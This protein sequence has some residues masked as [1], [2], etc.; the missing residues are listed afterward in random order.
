MSILYIYNYRYKICIYYYCYA[1]EDDLQYLVRHLVDVAHDWEKIGQV[2]S[3]RNIRTIKATYSDPQHCLVVM[4]SDWLNMAY[5]K[6]KHPEAPCGSKLVFAIAD[7]EGGC[8]LQLAR[9]LQTKIHGIIYF[10]L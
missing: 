7:K 2:L 4:L 8:N 6:K 3:V 10:T 5:D 1:G 9:S